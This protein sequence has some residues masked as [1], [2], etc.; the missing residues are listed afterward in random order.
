MTERSRAETAAL[1]GQFWTAV[2][3]PEAVEPGPCIEWPAARNQKGY[4]CCSRERSGEGI[5]SRAVWRELH[6]AIPDGL[7]VLHECDNPPCARPAHLFIGTAHENTQDMLRK[8]RDRAPAGNRSG[9]IVVPDSYV[10]ELRERWLAGESCPTLAAEAGMHPA[11]MSRLLRGLRRNVTTPVDP[12]VA[13]SRLIPEQR[14]AGRPRRVAFISPEK[15]ARRER[16]ERMAQMYANGWSTV[17]IGK[18]VGL[19]PATVYRRLTAMGVTMRS[20][21]DY[22]P[23]RDAEELAAEYRAGGGLVAMAAKHHMTSQRVAALIRSTGTPIRKPGRPVVAHEPK[24][25]A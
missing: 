23:A 8:G 1:V 13:A 4:G 3:A 17:R 9:K 5:V 24:E 15:L 10:V 12:A 14:R 22:Y 25:I 21:A 20:T 16:D 7:R 11:S 6:G 19:N 18:E 2:L